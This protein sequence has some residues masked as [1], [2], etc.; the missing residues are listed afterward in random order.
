MFF[1]VTLA[2]GQGLRM[3]D[4]FGDLR[5]FGSGDGDEVMGDFCCFLAANVDGATEELVDGFADGAF[6]FVFDG[7]ESGGD[8]LFFDEV[9][10][11]FDGAGVEFGEGLIGG[12]LVAKS[13]FGAENSEVGFLGAIWRERFR[14]VF[15]F[16]V[17][18]DEVGA[19]TVGFGGVGAEEFLGFV[20][21]VD[22]LGALF[23]ADGLGEFVDRFGE[24]GERFLIVGVLELDVGVKAGILVDEARGELDFELGGGA[25]VA[26]DF[27]RRF[28]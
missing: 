10:D 9:E 28:F 13:V 26:E 7:N 11:F 14:F 15:D 27:V 24:N 12:G 2:L 23:F 20:E 3:G 18:V 4:D 21:D 17:F 16:F 22:E 8:F 6:E 5:F 19:F 25:G 1:E